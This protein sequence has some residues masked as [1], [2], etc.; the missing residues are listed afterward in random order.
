MPSRLP[1]ALGSLLSGGA[2]A[3]QPDESMERLSAV[4]RLAEK[5]T[6]KIPIAS[7]ALK[8]GNYSLIVKKEK[9]KHRNLSQSPVLFLQ[10]ELFRRGKQHTKPRS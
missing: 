4:S 9:W 10:F 8:Y 5:Q 2:P 7:P 6:N 1:E 3:G